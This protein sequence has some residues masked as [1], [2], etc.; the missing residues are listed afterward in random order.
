MNREQI[1]ERKWFAPEEKD[2]ILSKSHGRCC[3]CGK[4]ISVG[5]DFTVEHIIPLS[6]GGTNNIENIVAL[7]KTC[8]DA[9]SDKVIHPSDYLKYIDDMY[10]CEILENQAKYYE[11]YNWFSQRNF[12]PIDKRTIEIEYYFPNRGRKRKEVTYTIKYTLDKATYEDLDRIY[13][14]IWRYNKKYGIEGT[15]ESL[16]KVMSDVFMRGAFYI[17]QNS[18][19][20]IIAVIPIGLVNLDVRYNKQ[21]NKLCILSILNTIC[22]YDKQAY[23]SLIVESIQYMVQEL[24]E[25]KFITKALPLRLRKVNNDPVSSYVFRVLGGNYGETLAYTDAFSDSLIL[26]S[27]DINGHNSYDFPEDYVVV[28]DTG[29]DLSWNEFY[30]CIAEFSENVIKTLDIELKEILFE[31]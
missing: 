30:E 2:F 7:C 4:K 15:R 6:K 8:N 17:I 1:E 31:V 12:I 14:F 27:K 16:K 20:E 5:K 10:L 26:L 29:Q 21:N 25:Q 19:H 24:K 13:E 23:K 22:M 28:K 11:K 9:K 18:S 3:H